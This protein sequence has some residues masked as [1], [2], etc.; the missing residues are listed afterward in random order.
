VGIRV[1]DPRKAARETARKRART[2]LRPAAVGTARHPPS[3]RHTSSSY[4]P[5]LYPIR[6]DSAFTTHRT[7]CG[8]D[9]AQFV[10][11]SRAIRAAIRSSIAASTYN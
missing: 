10:A 5:G 3:A 9:S 1:R 8:S 6:T 2:S 7:G 11:L 4:R